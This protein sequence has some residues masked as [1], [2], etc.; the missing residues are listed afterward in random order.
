[1]KLVKPVKLVKLVIPFVTFIGLF[2]GVT[3][4]QEGQVALQACGEA[5][6]LSESS[7]ADKVEIEFTSATSLAKCFNDLNG[8]LN[9]AG[10]ER[11]KGD[12]NIYKSDFYRIVYTQNG[13]EAMLVVRQ[14]DNVYKV[15]LD[16]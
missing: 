9:D 3:F 11:V 13:A 15:I 2:F 1:M 5:Q 14:S 8:Q 6:V 10:W 4:A 7:E 12:N 16:L